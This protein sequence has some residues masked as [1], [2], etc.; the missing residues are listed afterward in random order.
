MASMLTA[1]AVENAKGKAERYELPDGGSGLYLVVQPSGARSWAFRYRH[2]GKPRKLT[3][4]P[5]PIIPLVDKKDER[6]R[7]LV[8]GARTLAGQAREAV[9]AGGDPALEKKTEAAAG[10]NTLKAV[11]ESYL[12]REAKDLRSKDQIEKALGRLVYPDLGDREIDTIRRSEIIDLLDDIEDQR[13]PVM[14]D[15]TLAYLRKIMNWHAIR[16]DAF[17]SPIVRGMARTKP[18]KRSRDRILSDDELRAVWRAA[19]QS[20]APFECMVRFI[21]LTLT[22]RNEAARMPDTEIVGDDWIIP[23]ARYKTKVDHVIPLS[24]AAKDVLGSALRIE[25]VP[26]IFTTG[27]EPI[28]GF[29][30]FKEDFDKACG[31]EGWTLHDL[32]RT[33]RSLMS[34][35]GVDPDVAERCLGHVIAGVRGVYDRYAYHAEKRAAFEA[36]AQQIDIILS[37]QPAKVLQLRA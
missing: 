26:Y 24:N 10:T 12:K 8:K 15:R 25:G 3:L 28:S 7:V 37:A 33:G 4:G 21:L 14:S 11:C 5:F 13:G 9:E 31:V 6:G 22:R 35:A 2:F 29:S 19:E 34:R 23:A 30:K 20:K 27:S 32:R 1:K 18:S 17:N 16:S 36:L